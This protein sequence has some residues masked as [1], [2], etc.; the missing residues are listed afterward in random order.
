MFMILK[1]TLW[2]V[3]GEIEEFG[4]R[5]VVIKGTFRK[6]WKMWHHSWGHKRG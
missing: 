5:N 6:N 2:K 1:I 3:V 4:D